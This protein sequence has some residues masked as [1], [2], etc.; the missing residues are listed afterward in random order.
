MTTHNVNLET[1]EEI[2]WLRNGRLGRAAE[3][4]GVE[5]AVLELN[6]QAEPPLIQGVH[7]E[8]A[9]ADDIDEA[10][11]KFTDAVNMTASELRDWSDHAC[12]DEASLNP[13]TVRQRV[14]NLLETPKEDWGDAE[15]DDAGQVSQFIA[16]MRGMEQ[17]DSS[18]D[19]PSDRDI[20]L[21]N[22]GYR[23][24]GVSL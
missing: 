22:W 24:D 16:R 9:T 11:S 13:D 5:A 23:P 18:G 6:K 19:C 15:V 10:Y 20:S 4:G 2:D 21:M 17:G 8:G 14:L 3:A 7:V 12:S 1:G